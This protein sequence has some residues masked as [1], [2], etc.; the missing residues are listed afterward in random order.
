MGTPQRIQPILEGSVLNHGIT[1]SLGQFN[2][3]FGQKTH[4]ARD[5][6]AMLQL[7][8]NILPGHVA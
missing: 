8:P 2:T 5:L 4:Y 7:D 3:F 1:L 6:D